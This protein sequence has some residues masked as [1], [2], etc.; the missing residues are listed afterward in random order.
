MINCAIQAAVIVWQSFGVRV[1][2]RDY[3]VL[4]TGT[5]GEHTPE[6]YLRVPWAY[7]IHRPRHLHFFFLLHGLQPKKSRQGTPDTITDS[8]KVIGTLRKDG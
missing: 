3:P 5:D 6:N 8:G 2:C 1:H 7:A 4:S